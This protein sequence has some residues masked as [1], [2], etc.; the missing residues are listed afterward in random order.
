MNN[1]YTKEYLQSNITT[2]KDNFIYRIHDSFTL[3]INHKINREIMDNDKYK[4]TILQGFLKSYNNKNKFGS[5]LNAVRYYID[6]HEIKKYDQN[7]LVVH[8][9]MGDYITKQNNY[10][11]IINNITKYIAA[12]SSVK[13][14][15][16]VVAFHFG[17]P[18]ESN[19]MY[20]SG[21]YS[22]KES[23]ITR[24][25]EILHKFIHQ[26]NLPVIIESSDNVDNDLCLLVCASHLII[27]YGGFGK[28]AKKLNGICNNTNNKANDNIDIKKKKSKSFILTNLR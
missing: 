14:I 6:N 2:L 9:R 16:L 20:S 3:S 24:N 21:Q 1:H 27:S 26:M 13:Y 4:D 5:L 7:Y 12:H 11:S 10:N 19:E 8:L 22:F 25:I 15:V 28:L 23:Y 17:Q 18:I